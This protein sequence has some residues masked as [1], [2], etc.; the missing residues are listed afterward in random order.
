MITQEQYN[1]LRQPTRKLR[2]KID[3]INENDIVVDSLE[4]IAIDGN[5]TL[6]GKSAYNR[7]GN[8]TLVFDERYRLVPSPDSKI[9]LNKRMGITILVKDYFG[10]EIPFNLGRFAI[11]NSDLNFTAKE[12]TMSCELTD[13]IAFLDGT[14][15]GTL[16]NKIIIDEGTP[17]SEAI[18]AVLRDLIKIS[19]ENMRINDMELTVPYTIEKNAG[20]TAYEL[21]TELINLY[22]G[23]TFYVDENGFFIVEKIRDKST[24][25]VME[26]F[27]DND[28]LTLNFSSKADFTNV[29]NSVHVWGREL[30]DG[31]QIRWVY[32]NRWERDSYSDLGNLTDKQIGDICHIVNENNSY[33][34]NGE[35][36]ELLDFKV[37]PQF[38]IE[39]IGERVHVYNS[40]DIFT[41]LQARLRAEYE[42]QQKSN[43]AEQMT[44]TTVPIYYLRPL[45]KI[46]VNKNGVA[47]GYYLTDSISI[48][49]TN[50][51]E[52]NINCHKLYY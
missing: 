6:D 35:E 9:W 52:M 22:M 28:I 21:I 39:K 19:V 49:L 45:Q 5:I 11:K 14:L 13:Y 26:Y 44:F 16:P 32:R 48:P 8:L 27:D 15:G 2:L 17:I 38:N 41:D 50:L 24:D 10:N 34:W 36:W 20:A 42:L 47:E 33:M 31:T 40:D 1:V 3:L 12:K 43:L 18:K 29:K 4:G 37:V 46:Y 23:W 7:S 25:P 30:E 51:G